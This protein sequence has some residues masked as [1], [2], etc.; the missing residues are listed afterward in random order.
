MGN[1]NFKSSTDVETEI[2][3]GVET[4]FIRNESPSNYTMRPRFIYND[5]E[6]GQSVLAVINE[7]LEQCTEFW[8]SVAF[9]TMSGIESLKLALAEA[10]ERG[11]KGRILTSRYLDFNSPK[12]L[13]ELLKL[14]DV[15]VRVH[16]EQ[17]HSK[18]YCFK[19]DYYINLLIGSS[20]LTIRALKT[21]KEWNLRISSLDKG[22]VVQ[23]TF[24]EFEKM[25]SSSKPLTSQW[26]AEYESFYIPKQRILQEASLIPLEGAKLSPNSMQSE[27][28]SALQEVRNRDEKKALLI[29][30]TG[31]GKTY[32]SAFDVRSIRPKRLLFLAHREQLLQQAMKSYENVMGNTISMGILSGNSKDSKRNYLFATVQTIS[33]DAV[34]SQFTK[35]EF[36]YIIID[37][38][39]RATATSYNKIMDYF[40]PKF[41]LGM[42]ATPE[43]TD[44]GDVYALFDYN[45]AYEIRLQ[46]ALE[47]NLLCPFHYYGISDVQLV[48]DVQTGGQ[49]AKDLNFALLTSE[50]RM[51]HIFEKIEY[52]GHSGDRVKGL[53]FCSSV[54]ECKA[55]AEAFKRKNYRVVAL[56]G[57]DTQEVRAQAIRRLELPEGEEALDYILTVDIFNEGVDIP[58]INQ[59]VMLRPTQSAI[60]FV[61]QLGRGLRKYQSSHKN[62]E[63]LYDKKEFLVV[64]DF[65]GNYNNNFLI[66]IAL[67]GDTTFNKDNLRRQVAEG[68]Q[69]ISGASTI[70]IDRIAKEKIYKAIDNT[71]LNTISMLKSSYQDVKMKIGRIP[72]IIDFEKLG[73]V[74]MMNFFNHADL[75]SYYGFLVKYEKE[76]KIRFT[77]EQEHIIN[78]VCQ[79]LANGKRSQELTILKEL[80]YNKE[81]K[82][83]GS[84][85]L[86][87]N[88]ERVLTNQFVV[89]MQE[90]PKFEH[91][92]LVR[93]DGSVFSKTP[94]FSQA[95][96]DVEFKKMLEEVIDFGL[97]KF[98]KQYSKKYMDTGF[99]LN[100]KY[101]YGDVCR[102]LCWEQ[103]TL[104]QNIGGYKYDELTDTFPVFINYHKEDHIQESI[105]YED[106]FLSVERLIAYSKSKRRM[107][108]IDIQRL[109]KCRDMESNLK[110]YLFVRRDKND[111]DQAKEFYF[112]GEMRPINF[113]PKM[114][115]KNI[116]VV[117]IQYQLA[118]PVRNDLY[119]YITMGG[120]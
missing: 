91:A 68:N 9:V 3:R 10:A 86:L 54:Q 44:G 99:C 48:G 34:L 90:K 24:D 92:I 11:V 5:T 32:L 85:L 70:N 79:K 118:Q 63:G 117:E 65:I 7:E 81:S 76:F 62:S 110:I 6:S 103:N 18:G 19:N 107:D 33:K 42:T 58:A 14:K 67:S 41:V 36:D 12:A 71:K 101:T 29:S 72:D 50:E 21:N 26:I 20:N 22:E 15:E 95:I 43:R 84:N 28:L 30:A 45:V 64:I 112:L 108:S 38:V 87:Q 75:K 97:R 61:Q 1:I 51:R 37:E 114:M 106:E 105:K 47:A 56:S 23:S 83:D 98:E 88:L 66:P 120:D 60:I 2:K 57:A 109:Q 115:A 111:K 59:V 102:L 46:Q 35:G 74:D 94:I 55:L 100:E 96:S 53:V 16:E 73:A 25:W 52:Y 113:A 80:L 93:R 119:N 49:I 78:F 116:P 69:T 17:L 13:R 39:H 8:F 40:E 82:I 104:A 31:T 4:G 27:A 77:I 89:S